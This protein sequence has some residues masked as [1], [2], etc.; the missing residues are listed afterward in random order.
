MVSNIYG[1]RGQGFN[2][3]L[4]GIRAAAR[5]KLGSEARELNPIIAPGL[6]CT[7]ESGCCVFSSEPLLP[8][9]CLRAPEVAAVITTSQSSLSLL[10][11]LAIALQTGVVVPEGGSVDKR[12]LKFEQVWYI[13]A[14]TFR[15]T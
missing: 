2:L 14:D 8:F 11:S 9:S 6:G 1:H 12:I 10:A 5:T 15:G 13:S 7:V 3:T 4:T